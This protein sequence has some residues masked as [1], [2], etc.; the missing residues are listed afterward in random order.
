MNKKM[1]LTGLFSALLMSACSTTPSNHTTI[2]QKPNSQFE[3]TG[4]GKTE[5]IAKN[6]AANAANKSCGKLSH[7]KS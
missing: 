5:L 6:N 4:L 7:A 3:V 1:V 2:I